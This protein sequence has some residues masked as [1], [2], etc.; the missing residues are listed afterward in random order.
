MVISTDGEEFGSRPLVLF[1]EDGAAAEIGRGMWP[2][3][4]DDRTYGYVSLGNTIVL[5]AVGEPEP[6]GEL[7][8]AAL[9]AALPPDSAANG[10]EI[11]WA[12]SLA[13]LGR[14]ALLFATDTISGTGFGPQGTYAFVIEPDKA[15]RVALNLEPPIVPWDLPVVSPDG[16]WLAVYTDAPGGPAGATSMAIHILDL[17][18]RRPPI[19]LDNVST[20]RPTGPFSADGEWLVVA[21]VSFLDLVYLGPA[22]H[23]GEPVHRYIFP[24]QGSCQEAIW[25]DR[26]DTP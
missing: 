21:R 15:P 11:M 26:S 16:R 8:G 6:V 17:E 12:T 22:G 14:H 10:L 1:D 20:T 7:D 4:L 13:P 24:A 3:W 18:G 25:L 2:F 19:V 9:R 23:V 5:A